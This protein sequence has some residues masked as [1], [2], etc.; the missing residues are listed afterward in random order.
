MLHYLK[1]ILKTKKVHIEEQKIFFK[2]V[3]INILTAIF[4]KIK[5]NPLD[6]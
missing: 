6:K 2:N 5:S 4:S 3:Y 1:I